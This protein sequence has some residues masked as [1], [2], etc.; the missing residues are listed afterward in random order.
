MARIQMLRDAYGKPL[1]VSS[2]ARCP[3]H[4]AKVSKTGLTGPH[5]TGRAVDLSV[6][7]ADAYRVLALALSMGFTGIGVQQKGD[8]RFIHLDDLPGANRLWSY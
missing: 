7:R 1:G 3:T 6:D 8:G 2:A 5:T 4:N